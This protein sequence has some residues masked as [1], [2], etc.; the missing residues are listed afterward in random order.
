MEN[1]ENKLKPFLFGVG[2]GVLLGVILY[3]IWKN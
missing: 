1:K 3:A 2:G